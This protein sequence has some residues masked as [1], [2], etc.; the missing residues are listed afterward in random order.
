MRGGHGFTAEFAAPINET[1]RDFGG[2]L[3]DLGIKQI[4][5]R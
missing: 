2:L 5:V 1:V 4:D 3:T